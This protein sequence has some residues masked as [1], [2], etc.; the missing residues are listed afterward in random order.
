MTQTQKS[1]IL[2]LRAEGMQYKQIAEQT[3]LTLASVKMFFSRQ[4]QKHCTQCGK[5]LTGKVRRNQRFCS[6]ACKTKWW[7]TH[8]DMLKNSNRPVFTCA[9]CG[10]AFQAYKIAKYCSRTCFL[11]AIR[12]AQPDPG[13]QTQ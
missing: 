2:S 12:T 7:N 5:L 1:Q 6:K 9:V 8:T 4:K 3:G 10:K 11:K 13:I